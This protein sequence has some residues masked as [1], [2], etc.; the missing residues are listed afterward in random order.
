V[1]REMNMYVPVMARLF[2]MGA[3]AIV[4]LLSVSRLGV[5]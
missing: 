3:L 2:A 4:V 1:K 5:A